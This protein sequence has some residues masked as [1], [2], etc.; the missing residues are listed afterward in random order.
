MTTWNKDSWLEMLQLVNLSY[1]MTDICLEGEGTEERYLMKYGYV[2]KYVDDVAYFGKHFKRLKVMEKRDG[3][4]HYTQRPK[5]L[6]DLLRNEEGPEDGINDP[7]GDPHPANVGKKAAEDG[8]SQPD[9]MS[10]KLRDYE[11]VG[12]F[13]D[14]GAVEGNIFRRNGTYYMVFNGSQLRDLYSD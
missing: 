9:A 11:W 2:P 1:E 4:L 7:A 10:P 5:S 12:R 8:E 13:S 14:Y 3:N 6:S